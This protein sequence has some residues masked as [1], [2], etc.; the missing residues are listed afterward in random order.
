MP[1]PA[2]IFAFLSDD[3]E[4]P[5]IQ[6]YTLIS[7]VDDDD[8]SSCLSER[9][10][11]IKNSTGEFHIFESEIQV[12]AAALDK[13]WAAD[14]KLSFGVLVPVFGG[15]SCRATG[16]LLLVVSAKTNCLS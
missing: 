6:I 11:T 9:T 14:I 16:I 10:S 12:M 3:K 1:R 8:A 7:S 5:S 2:L 4:L 13:C 15:A